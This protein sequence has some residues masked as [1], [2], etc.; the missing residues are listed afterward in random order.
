M[1]Y[2]K[3]NFADFHSAEKFLIMLSF[4]VNFKF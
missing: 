2:E 4:E 3:Y 1:Q